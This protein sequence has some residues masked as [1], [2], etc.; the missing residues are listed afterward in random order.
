MHNV[1]L[2]RGS[3]KIMVQF[4][5]TGSVVESAASYQRAFRDAYVF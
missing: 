1:F 5:K 2:V 3:E 4:R